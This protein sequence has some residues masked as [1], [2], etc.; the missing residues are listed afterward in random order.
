MILSNKD[1]CS[2]DTTNVTMSNRMVE[3]NDIRKDIIVGLLYTE[4]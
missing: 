4:D 2:F 1:I 3:C